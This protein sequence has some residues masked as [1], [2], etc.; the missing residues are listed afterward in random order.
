M[1]NFNVM[2]V[3]AYSMDTNDALIFCTDFFCA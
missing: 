2:V 3:L 1:A